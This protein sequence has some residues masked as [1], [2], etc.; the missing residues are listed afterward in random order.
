MTIVYS[1]YI[2]LPFPNQHRPCLIGGWKTT[3]HQQLAILRLKLLVGEVNPQ[4]IVMWLYSVI[5]CYN[6]I[7]IS[8]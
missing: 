1:D 2:N 7:S 4:I 5:V 3:F 8:H 6:F